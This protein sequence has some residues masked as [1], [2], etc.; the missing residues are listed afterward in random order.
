M[1]MVATY[2][3]TAQ[4]TLVDDTVISGGLSGEVKRALE[5]EGYNV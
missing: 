5:N 3:P 1:R 4:G 2:R